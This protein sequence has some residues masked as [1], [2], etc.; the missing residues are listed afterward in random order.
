MAT[1]R[2]TPPVTQLISG[3]EMKRLILEIASL[4]APPSS[5]ALRLGDKASIPQLLALDMN[6]WIYLAKAHYGRPERPSHAAALEAIRDATGAGALIAPVFPM[7]LTEV[8]DI[9]AGDRRARLAAFMVSL[10]QNHSIV[11]SGTIREHE[12]HDA[13]QARYLARTH[14]SDV[15]TRILHWGIR[16]AVGIGKVQISTRSG[17]AVPADLQRLLD[18][19]GAHP[20]LSELALANI[21]SSEDT[22]SNRQL[23]QDAANAMALARVGC[24]DLTWD[25]RMAAETWNLIQRGTV[26]E[27]IES[28]LVFNGLA[29]EPFFKWLEDEATRVAF[30]AAIPQLN[31]QAVLTL[32]RD[33]NRD[34]FP[35]RNDLKDLFF[36]GVA[37]PYA[38]F[39]ITEKAWGHLARA[40]H[41][42]EHYGTT[43]LSL[44]DL[45][46]V[47]RER[48]VSD[49]TGSHAQ[50]AKPPVTTKEREGQ[51]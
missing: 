43:V 36:L 21:F 6:A 5:R 50:A 27:A 33:R 31:V 20:T 10:S 49:G 25:E 35:D 30:F 1:H 26:R 32:T 14:Q 44:E 28:V 8:T 40:S 19:V 38:N 51:L 42:A 2:E 41:L 3:D 12:I 13:I 16:A 15:R 11:Y 48:L 24:T 23:D 34:A 46:A 47:L 18:E 37:L 39:V 7:N 17:D 22:Q 45:P 29:G 4:D 9:S